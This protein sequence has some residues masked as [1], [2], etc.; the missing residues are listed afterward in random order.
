MDTELCNRVTEVCNN[1]FGS[2]MCLCAD[3]YEIGTEEFQCEGIS[4]FY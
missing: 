3:G 2:Y 4:K 1:T